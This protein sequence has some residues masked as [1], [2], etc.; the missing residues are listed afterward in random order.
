MKIKGFIPAKFTPFVFGFYMAAIMAFLMSAVLVAINTGTG[1]NYVARVFGS[2]VIAFP[3]AF[4]CV[5][6]VRPLV[7]KLVNLT[8]K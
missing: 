5:T 6:I 3:V 8:V 7:Q 2:Y 4:C 1:G